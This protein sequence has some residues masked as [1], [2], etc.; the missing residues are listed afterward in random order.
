MWRNALNLCITDPV[1]LA[2][3][4]GLDL[5]NLQDHMKASQRY[6]LRI[7]P[8]YFN[9]VK[10]G[11]P[12]DPIL[13][14]ILPAP[15]ELVSGPHET[16]DPVSESQFCP[17]PGLIHRYSHRALLLVT[18][19]CAVH[20]RFC[21][22][23]S[24]RRCNGELSEPHYFNFRDGILDYL[25]KNPEIYEVILSGGDPL[26]MD[27]VELRAVFR[28]LL[29]IPHIEIIR[30]HTRIPVV[31]PARITHPFVK[32]FENIPTCWMVTHF[33]HPQEFSEDSTCAC[34]KLIESGIPIL[35]QTVLLKGVNDS[36][37]VLESLC[38]SLIRRKIKPYY[39]HILDPA[40]GTSHF[41]IPQDQAVKLIQNLQSRLPGYALPRLAVD[42]PGTDGKTLLA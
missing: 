1:E 21:F 33:N 19:E 25:R 12:N 31:L 8:H 28:D 26:M 16:P 18:G 38:R 42:I 7:T 14:Q 22:R 39:V 5:D 34:L 40:Y 27:D 30:I 9:L 17:V 23:K 29:A 2:D 24:K 15:G 6:P 13:R 36:V 37:D 10:R 35:N 11:D 32:I 4:L 3:K 41:H 20:C